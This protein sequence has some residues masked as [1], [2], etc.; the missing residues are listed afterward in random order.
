MTKTEIDFG[1]LDALL[2]F[3]VTKRFCADYLKVSEDTI[4]RRI[5]EDH[6][7]T[8]GEYQSLRMGRTAVKIQ[9]KIV[10]LALKGNPKLLEV[11]AKYLAGWTEKSDISI[12]ASEQGLTLAYSIEK[13]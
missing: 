12:T 5:R 11:A 10:E 6:N 13:K 7:M 2:Q 3:K 4:D 9:Q 1:A 8:F